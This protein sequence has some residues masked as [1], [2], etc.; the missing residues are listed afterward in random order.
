MSSN[1]ILENS[2]TVNTCT[3]EDIIKILPQKYTL[4]DEV[5]IAEGSVF[6]L[7]I[8]R[9][10][11][12]FNDSHTFEKAVIEELVRLKTQ[13]SILNEKLNKLDK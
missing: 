5:T 1:N 7:K 13:I 6:E 8:K 12:S 10:T 11:T 9:Y 4:F 2:L 3:S